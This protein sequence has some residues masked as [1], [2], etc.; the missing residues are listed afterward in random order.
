MIREPVELSAFDRTVAIRRLPVRTPVMRRDPEDPARW[1]DVCNHFPK[2][3]RP[4]WQPATAAHP[5]RCLHNVLAAT[6]DNGRC[7]GLLNHQ[8]CLKQGPRLCG[9]DVLITP[10]RGEGAGTAIKG[11]APRSS[12]LFAK[13]F[14]TTVGGDEN[15]AGTVAATCRES[16]AT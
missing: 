9:V 7:C 3:N 13:C 8:E 11:D 6:Q 4:E 2:C 15:F 14:D 5:S 10:V 1:R 16:R 12:A